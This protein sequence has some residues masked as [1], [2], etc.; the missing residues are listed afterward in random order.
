MHVIAAS[1]ALCEERDNMNES[2]EHEALLSALRT[3]ETRVARIEAALQLESPARESE[4]TAY[5]PSE[6][7]AEAEALEMRIGQSW[8]P[9]LGIIMLA[10]GVGFLLTIPYPSLPSA[11]PSLFGFAIA[12]AIIAVSQYWRDTFRNI[13]GYLL[14][15]GIVLLFFA[16][17]RLHFF[18]TVPALE[19]R[20]LVTALLAASVVV[21]LYFSIV[22]HSVY[23]VAIS[24]TLGY[25][26]ALVSDNYALIF[27]TLATLSALGVFCSLK[28]HWTML[29]IFVA[30]MNILAHGIWFLNTP[31]LGRPVELVGSP[32]VNV[33]FVLAYI[34]IVAVGTLWRGERD[35]ESAAAI[36]SSAA[37]GLGGY[38]LFLFLTLAKFTEHFVGY[39]IAASFI[40]LGI[41]T[42]FWVRERSKYSTFIYA[43]LGYMALSAA[44][45]A[46]FQR[47]D[48][49]IWLSWQSIIVVSTA[50]WFRSRFIVVANFIIYLF[51]FGAYLILAG[52]IGIITLSFGVVALLSARILN[53]QKHSLEL[54]TELMRNAYLASAFGVFPYALYHTVPAAMLSLSWL[55]VALFY[56]IMARTIHSSKYRWMSLLTLLLTVI[57]VL[58]VD[59][60]GLDAV[61]K[62]ISFIVLGVVLLAISLAY[63]RRK[64]SKAQPGVDSD[65]QA[66]Q[67]S[68]PLLAA[69]DN[70]PTNS[71]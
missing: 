31:I 40:L 2:P 48:H 21:G 51:L 35:K 61:Y 55:A 57:H 34:S 67:P 47:P 33:L 44:I 59:I 4:I 71:L 50:V 22:R 46:Q 49:F 28:Y 10:I 54:K 24:L 27:L 53:A 38:L 37:N 23:L 63:S 62:V 32:E 52:K 20:T 43:M 45:V 60:T 39:Q 26:A 12:F 29:P 18:S 68:T 7:T 69:T 56:Y 30:M 5:A 6:E 36:L 11:L 16:T 17:L 41:A 8:F 9:K 1:F 42:L 64:V 25:A 58:A 70:N 65:Q 14:G 15:G 66:Q 3:L 19:S 13:S